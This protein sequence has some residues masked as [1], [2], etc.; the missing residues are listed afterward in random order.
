MHRVAGLSLR[1]FLKVLVKSGLHMG[2]A[3]KA[4]AGRTPT[5]QTVDMLRW[6]VDEPQMRA[7]F[8]IG[9]ESLSLK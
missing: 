4:T 5:S 6:P 8:M 3:G 1:S 2:V 9:P 7:E